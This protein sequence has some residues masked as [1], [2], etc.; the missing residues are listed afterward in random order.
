VEKA[1]KDY[2]ATNEQGRQNVVYVTFIILKR[3]PLLSTHFSSNTTAM[4]YV[5]TA[6]A[7]GEE[8]GTNRIRS[9][10]VFEIPKLRAQ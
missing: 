10:E 9:R 3:N 5:A 4:L 6:D 1:R 8:V 2:E 7:L